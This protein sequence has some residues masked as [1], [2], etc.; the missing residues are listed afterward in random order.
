MNEKILLRLSVL[1]ATIG[2]I[3]LLLFS[4]YHDKLN[5]KKLFLEEETILLEGMIT[6]VKS[7]GNS[8]YITLE[9]KKIEQVTV[10]SNISLTQGDY[11]KIEGKRDGSIIADR[12]E[13]YIPDKIS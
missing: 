5:V 11:I 7:R 9:T 4:V 3:F 10:F 6:S 13:K 8:A 2:I 12:I 1:I